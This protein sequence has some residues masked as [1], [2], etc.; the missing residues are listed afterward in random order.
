MKWVE[1]DSA[2]EPKS[3]EERR[4]FAE[5]EFRVETQVR[6]H[7]LLVSKGLSQKDLAAR[8]RVSQARVSQF[9]SDDCNL[10]LRT[11]AQIFFAIG[12]TPRINTVTDVPLPGAE[13][14][15][16]PN[17]RADSCCLP[18]RL[19]SEVASQRK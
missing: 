17:T 18:R 7:E 15:P 2:L 10:T 5:E 4:I 1:D 6:I 12:E 16:T 9:F 13:R 8:L 14:R 3:D 11:I 19:R